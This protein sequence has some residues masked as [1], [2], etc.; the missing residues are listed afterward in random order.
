MVNCLRS[1]IKHSLSRR[2]VQAVTDFGCSLRFP[3][4]GFIASFRIVFPMKCR[5]TEDVGM[6]FWLE[7]KMQAKQPPGNTLQS[8]LFFVTKLSFDET[9]VRFSL[10]HYSGGLW[11]MTF[12]VFDQ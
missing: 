7:T 2:L 9:S 5:P 4:K 1:G 8:Y 6:Y 3:R 10:S 11:M 12:T